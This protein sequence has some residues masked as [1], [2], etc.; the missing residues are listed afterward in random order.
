MSKPR[1]IGLVLIGLAAWI[2]VLNQGSVK[3]NLLVA[4]VSVTESILIL[5]SVAVGVIIG[6][7]VK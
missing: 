6:L 2:A 5:A 1:L 3:L 7:L 4:H